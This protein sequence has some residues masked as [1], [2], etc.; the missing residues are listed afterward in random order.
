VRSVAR[1]ILAAHGYTVRE[2]ANG[3]EALRVYDEASVSI[4]L[5]VTDVVMPEMSGSEMVRQLRQRQPDLCVLFMSGYT[6]EAALGPTLLEPRSAFIEKPF[7]PEALVARVRQMLDESV[8]EN[9]P[10]RSE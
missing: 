10:T 7:A 1:R 5:V 3:A 2:A 8:P 4:D 6:G 9:F